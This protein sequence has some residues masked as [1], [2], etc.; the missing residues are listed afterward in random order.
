MSGMKRLI[1]DLGYHA[2]RA[3]ARRALAEA[4]KHWEPGA[5][6][7]PGHAED[8]GCAS[9]VERAQERDDL[10]AAVMDGQECPECYGRGRIRLANPFHSN[11]DSTAACI[12]CRGTGKVGSLEDLDEDRLEALAAELDGR[13]M[14]DS[15]CVAGRF[16]K[17]V[18][19]GE[20]T[21][22]GRRVLFEAARNW[23]P[24]IDPLDK[25]RLDALAAELDAIDTGD[26][27]FI[28][29]AE[30]Q[31]R[32]GSWDDDAAGID[33]RIV[34]SGVVPTDDDFDDDEPEVFP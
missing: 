25:D 24:Q 2:S 7:G 22:E 23:D 9:C 31:R 12:A 6:D 29:D 10:G 11:D 32:L 14:D 34:L 4:A 15:A 5:D 3:E 1:E 27:E 33:D 8:C 17:L 30:R 18:A 28:T 16:H 13:E 26:A 21:K 20:R 19:R